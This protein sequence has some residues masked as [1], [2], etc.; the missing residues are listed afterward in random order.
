MRIRHVSEQLC[1]KIKIYHIY[2]F[3]VNSFVDNLSGAFKPRGN[4]SKLNTGFVCLIKKVSPV[5]D[6]ANV[7]SG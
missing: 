4:N 2:I 5:N 7:T 3:R 1:G 6:I